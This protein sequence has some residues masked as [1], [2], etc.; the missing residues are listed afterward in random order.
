MCGGCFNSMS[1]KEFEEFWFSEGEFIPFTIFCLSP[2]L[3][4]CHICF[5]FAEPA[6]LILF[7]RFMHLKM[8]KLEI[9]WN[10]GCFDS[11]FKEWLRKASPSPP[12]QKDLCIFLCCG[13]Q[14]GARRCTS[15]QQSHTEAVLWLD[16]AFPKELSTHS[17]PAFLLLA[18][19]C[20][21]VINKESEEPRNCFSPLPFRARQSW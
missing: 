12:L 7:Y 6:V 2:P 13:G 11:N 8:L 16:A 5:H 15:R 10:S 14:S 20:H 1:K 18:F 9:L 3:C 19:W 4:Y 17:M 21:S